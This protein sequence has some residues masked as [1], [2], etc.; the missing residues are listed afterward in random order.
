MSWIDTEARKADSKKD[1]VILENPAARHDL[2]DLLQN[3]FSPIIWKN[4][5]ATGYHFHPE[6]PEISSD[7]SRIL[8]RSVSFMLFDFLDFPFFLFPARASF[9]PQFV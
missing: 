7:L 3:H 5:Q 1:L 6:A 2:D 4:L 9:H 8:V